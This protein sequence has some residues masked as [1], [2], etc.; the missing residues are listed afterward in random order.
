M[1]EKDEY[2]EQAYF[3]GALKERLRESAPLQELLLQARE[4]LL[5]TCRLP[6]AVDFLLAELKH[7]GL[8][9]S[10]MARLPHYFTSFQTF[11]IAE[12]ENERGRFDLPVALEV[13]CAEANYRAQAAPPAGLF[14]FQFEVLCRNRLKYDKGFAAMAA[15][16]WYSS[17]WS[18]W[19]DTVRRQVGLVDF[20]DFIY[21]RSEYY[22]VQKARQQADFTPEKPIL[23][24][25]KE[26]RIALANRRKDP[27]F[28]FAAL[29]RHLG[30]PPVPRLKK[31]DDTPSLIPQLLRRMERLEA[32][33][34]LCEEE[35]RGGIDLTKLYGPDPPLPPD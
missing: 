17:D 22:V 4:E 12:A 11:L 14:V 29:Q 34:K 6:M 23:F 27:L 18:E 30:Y 2:V 33:I 10:A 13:L 31:F 15:D 24:G 25:A 20:A 7:A 19:I 32:R 9:S 26:G 28:L 8:M 5:A 16:P 35:Q 3:F 1:L 21:V